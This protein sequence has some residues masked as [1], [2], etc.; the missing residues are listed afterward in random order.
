M[1]VAKVGQSTVLTGKQ[2]NLIRESFVDQ[3]YR[4]IWDIAIYTGERW[5]AILQLQFYDVYDVNGEVR[6]EITFKKE[7]RKKSAGKEAKTRQVPCH[8]LLREALLNFTP[9]NSKYLFPGRS[10]DRPLTFRSADLAL[11]EAMEKCGLDNKGISTHSTRR[12]FI[13]RLAQSGIPLS[14]VQTIV[15]H[16]DVT[17]TRRYIE[18][19]PDEIKQAIIKLSF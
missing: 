5:G 17:T 8:P 18:N 14:T 1:K 9:S 7:T 16:S 3:K 11:R 15:G 12:T 4:L 19:D 10:G 6:G 2:I 13:T